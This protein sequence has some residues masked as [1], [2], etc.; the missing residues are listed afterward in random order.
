ML[1]W[2]ASRPFVAR[3]SWGNLEHLIAAGVDGRDSNA[4]D[5]G[6]PSQRNSANL[7]NAGGVSST[8][9]RREGCQT[10]TH[11]L[12]HAVNVCCGA[13]SFACSH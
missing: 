13:P 1:C 7:A 4:G 10:Q 11:D 3:G 2:R 6:I 8:R 5:A 9:S 12:A